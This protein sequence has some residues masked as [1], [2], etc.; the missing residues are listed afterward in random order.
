MNRSPRKKTAIRIAKTALVSRSAAD[1]AMGATLHT[2]R[3][4]RYEADD[5]IE[6]GS[7]MRHVEAMCWMGDPRCRCRQASLTR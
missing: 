3:I 2:H 6:A 4:S 5:A 7:D 1:G